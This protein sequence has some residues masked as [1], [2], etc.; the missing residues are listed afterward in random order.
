MG[1]PSK[2]AKKIRVASDFDL[3]RLAA[4]MRPPKVSTGL[5]AWELDSIRRAR[6]EQMLGRFELPARLAEATW[7]DYAIFSAFLNRLAPQR[8]LPI[9]L[10]PPNDSAR[11]ARVLSEA[12]A[13]FGK[14]GVG[15]SPDTLSDIDGA[16][17]NHGVAFAINVVTPRDDGSRIDFEVKTWPIEFVRWD[18]S[19]RAF[20]ARLEGGCE[21]TICHGDGRW[22]VFQM[23]EHEPWKHGSILPAGMLWA[24]HAIGVRDRSHAGTIR[25]NGKYVGTLPE[26]IALQDEEGKLTPEAAAFVQL[27]R[28]LASVESPVGLKPFGAVLDL[29]VDN[30]QGWQIFKEIIDGG[31]KAADKIYIGRDSTAASAGGDGVEFMFGVRDDIVEGTC[32]AISRGLL[33]GTIEPWAALN[34]GDSQLAPTRVY[35]LPDADQDARLKSLAER[36]KAF[37]DAIDQAKKNGFE[38]DQAYVDALAKEFDI[39]APKLPT[40]AAKGPSVTLAPTDVAKVTKVNEARA[41]AGLEA[42]TKPDGSPDPDGEL[43]VS[44]FA[45]KQD[46][47][48]KA[49][50]PPATAGAPPPNP[51]APPGA[52]PPASPVAPP[53][54]A[55]VP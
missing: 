5:Y 52:P 14:N 18:P 12:E 23:H 8:G 37:Y 27:M 28:D 35:L 33:E 47:V 9:A 32:N 19:R 40:Q 4:E 42:L 55:A 24:D 26:G 25:G 36:T 39:K 54:L 2:R 30:S 16:L 50:I 38:V 49:L 53:K 20:R 13:L 51:S 31:D 3:I 44:T 43:M 21:E 48:F 10:K 6:D 46:A 29:I 34:Y 11:A 41:S 7:T 17:A 22:I 1:A 15:I 45:A